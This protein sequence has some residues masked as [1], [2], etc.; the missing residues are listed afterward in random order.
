MFIT[1]NLT[2]EPVGGGGADVVV[3][4]GEAVVPKN[5]TRR[6]R[7]FYTFLEYSPNISQVHYHT[8][9]A[10]DEFFYFFYN[11]TCNFVAQQTIFS[12]RLIIKFSLHVRIDVTQMLLLIAYQQTYIFKRPEKKVN[13]LRKNKQ[14]F[15][16]YNFKKALKRVRIIRKVISSCFA[17]Y[18]IMFLARQSNN[19]I[20]SS[21]CYVSVC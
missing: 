4:P 9:N 3:L 17:A 16:I 1:L 5:S 12:N 13:F 19:Q 8:I 6:S 20:F 21:T 18:D 7:V 11:I 15:D 14:I 2:Y 10:Q